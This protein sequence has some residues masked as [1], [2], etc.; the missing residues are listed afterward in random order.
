MGHALQAMATMSD[1]TE[2]RDQAM[3]LFTG[4][5]MSHDETRQAEALFRTLERDEKQYMK[6]T[7]A[8]HDGKMEPL[9]LSFLFDQF[10]QAHRAWIGSIDPP[11]K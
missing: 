11:H 3:S 1:P 10:A 9:E 2:G 6:A 7:R 5:K 8:V 4:D